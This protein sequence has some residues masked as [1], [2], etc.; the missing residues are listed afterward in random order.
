M[1]LI[2]FINWGIL[3]FPKRIPYIDIY[4]YVKNCGMQIIEMNRFQILWNKKYIYIWIMNDTYSSNIIIMYTIHIM[5][6]NVGQYYITTIKL[7]R[8]SK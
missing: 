7:L 6:N 3:A 4:I 1:A 8:S 5:I 2:Y